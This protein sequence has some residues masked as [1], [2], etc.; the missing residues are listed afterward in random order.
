M[1]G[2]TNFLLGVLVG[3]FVVGAGMI[4]FVMIEGQ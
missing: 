1:M 4:L 2:M 3:A